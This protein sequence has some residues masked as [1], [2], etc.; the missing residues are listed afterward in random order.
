MAEN[1]EVFHAKHDMTAPRFL[2]SHLVSAVMVA[3]AGKPCCDLS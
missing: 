1:D 3:E 2:S